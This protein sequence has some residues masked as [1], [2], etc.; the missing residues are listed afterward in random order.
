[1]KP[2]VWCMSLY[3]DVSAADRNQGRDPF[4]RVSCTELLPVYSAMG[5]AKLVLTRSI[6]TIVLKPLMSGFS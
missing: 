4:K 1:M 2:L 6:T 3:P 5:N